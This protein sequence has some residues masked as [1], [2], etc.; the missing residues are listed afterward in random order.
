MTDPLLDG[1]PAEGGQLRQPGRGQVTAVRGELPGEGGDLLH[2][3][4]LGEE[5]AH[6]FEGQELVG[7][8]THETLQMCAQ[9]GLSR[10]RLP[11]DGGDPDQRSGALDGDHQMAARLFQPLPDGQQMGVAQG[12]ATPEERVAQH[13]TGRVTQ[14]VAE[15]GGGDLGVER[16]YGGAAEAA[17]QH[18]G[19]G[20]AAGGVGADQDDVPVG[21]QPVQGGG[22][23][24]ALLERLGQGVDLGR[25]ISPDACAGP[26]A[27]W[28]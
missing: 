18:Q 20:A 13:M 1:R 25:G 6:R 5:V 28:W 16:P 9:D 2:L 17:Q 24:V 21:A 26:A 22:E 4:V 23:G 27:L 12:L 14:L 10:G 15:R 19:R 11:D 7:G 8:R 3:V